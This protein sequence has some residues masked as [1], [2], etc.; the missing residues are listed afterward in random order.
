MDISGLLLGNN[1]NPDGTQQNGY[2]LQLETIRDSLMTSPLSSN[3]YI[4]RKSDVE[5]G[6][7]ETRSECPNLA[8]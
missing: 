8:L 5:K 3:C 2:K 4:L 6:K 7:N 1:V